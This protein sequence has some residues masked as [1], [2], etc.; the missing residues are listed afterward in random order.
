MLAWLP[1]D[2]DE[3]RVV[4]AAA[5][6]GIALGSLAARRIE[7]GPGGL[8]FGYGVIAEGAIEPGVERLAGIVA[9]TRAGGQVRA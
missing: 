6:A 4:D 1:D 2:V 7:P 3:A 5:A 8:V 9:A